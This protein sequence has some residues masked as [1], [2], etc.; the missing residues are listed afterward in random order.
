[1]L[2]KFSF[3]FHFHYSIDTLGLQCLCEAAA[4]KAIPKVIKQ[5]AMLFDSKRLKWIER[6]K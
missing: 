5:Y 1:M 3:C 2:A 6:V 4:A